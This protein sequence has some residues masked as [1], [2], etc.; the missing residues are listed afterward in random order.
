MK[1]TENPTAISLFCG[2]GGC[3]YGFQQARFDILYASDINKT[4]VA[5]YKTN[6]P[7]TKVEQ[8]D[9]DKIDFKQLL[10][11]LNLLPEQLDILIGGPPCQ[12]FST[13]G[14]RFWDDPRNHLLKSYVHALKIL[15]PKWF[16]MENVEGLLTANRGTYITEAAKAFIE[17]GYEIRIE[18]IYA[19]EYGIPQRRKR[20]V[21]VGN[22]LG[23]HFEMPRPTSKVSGR[24][25]KDSENTISDAIADLPAPAQKH[26]GH[27]VLS[28]IHDILGGEKK[29]KH[30]VDDHCSPIIEGIQKE[31]ICALKPGQ[32]MKDLPD[33]LQHDSFKKRANRRV[34]DGMPTEKRGGPPS[35]LKRLYAN[36]PC[37]TITGAATREL[38]HPTQ[39]RPLTLRECARIQT[40]PDT[41]TFCG[42]ASE[43]IQ[44][45]GNAIPPMLAFTFADHIKKQYGFQINH[46]SDGRLLGTVLTKANAMSPA[47]ARTNELLSQLQQR[48]KS[49]QLSLFEKTYA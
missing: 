28:T 23:L 13:A 43:R 5:T 11:D 32:T 1:K 27:T 9:I 33:R 10:L 3:S 40:F 48:K 14:S 20:V 36:Q 26:G 16:L 38:I 31:R 8:V 17:L 42:S 45:I 35:G 4:A 18:K 24:I 37:L 29:K 22:R 39:D 2:A 15:K 47:L 49:I 44:Q 30:T 19:H 46:A 6:F 21:I 12:G 7:N 41:F 34:A 25:F